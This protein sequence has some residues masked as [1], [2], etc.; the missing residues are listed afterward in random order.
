[1]PEP[2][3]VFM[4]IIAS[5][6]IEGYFIFEHIDYIAGNPLIFA[7]A[8]VII[9]FTIPGAILA[10]IGLDSLLDALLLAVGLKVVLRRIQPYAIMI[11]PAVGNTKFFTIA[12]RSG[13]I[14]GKIVMFQ[15]R[16]Q[17]KED[18]GTQ[19]K[20][21]Y[22]THIFSIRAAAV[23]KIIKKELKKKKYSLPS[24]TMLLKS[25][26]TG[27]TLA[28]SYARAGYRF[29]PDTDADILKTADSSGVTV[30][31][32]QAEEGYVFDPEK[33]KD[34]VFLKDST[35]RTVLDIQ[36]KLLLQKLVKPS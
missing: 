13:K 29:N 35:G 23:E 5:L 18:P 25:D 15:N 4:F 11:T 28:H 3:Y 6:I 22:L 19:E 33:H 16:I 30:A 20:S 9:I 26:R 36:N 10:A 27:W 1:M 2:I 7:A 17:V 8:A 31:H 32:V 12:C 21:F 14:S 34:I 24:R